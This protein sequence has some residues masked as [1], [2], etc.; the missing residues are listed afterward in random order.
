MGKVG[1]DSEAVAGPTPAQGVPVSGGGLPM[2]WRH[3]LVVLFTLSALADPAR[4]GIL[5]GKKPNKPNPAERVPELIVT[6][7]TDGD[8]HKRAAA[9]E[10]LRQYD[11][12]TF[13]EIVP[14]LIDVL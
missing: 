6:V 2:K 7:K 11:P 3:F 8:E 14:V 1:V 10:E 12:A 5:F 13:T 4:A 9:A